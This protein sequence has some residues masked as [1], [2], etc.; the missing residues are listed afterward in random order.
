MMYVYMG[1]YHS[2]SKPRVFWDAFYLE[3]KQAEGKFHYIG[4]LCLCY[5]ENLKKVLLF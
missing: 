5:N 3:K 4:F 2:L 1:L